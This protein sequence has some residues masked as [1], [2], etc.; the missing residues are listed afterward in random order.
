LAKFA[1][2]GNL[3]RSPLILLLLLLL[4]SCRA[5]RINPLDPKSPLFK[6]EGAISGTIRDWST[7]PVEGARIELEPGLF[8]ATSGSGGRYFIEK[9]HSGS[10]TA[11]SSKSFYS[12]E[13]LLVDVRVG[14]TATFDFRLDHLAEFSGLRASTHD[15]SSGAGN[16]LYATFEASVTDP[17]GFVVDTLVRL[18]VD[19]TLSRPMTYLGGHSF[20]VTLPDDSLPGGSLEYLAGRAIRLEATD[21]AGRRSVSDPF[22]I[23]RIIYQIPMALSP[24]GNAPQNPVTFKWSGPKPG[25][26]FS[27]ALHVQEVFP[28]N[29]RSWVREGIPSDSTSFYLS[30]TLTT[31]GTFLWS[32]R[33]VDMFG[34][35]ATSQLEM[36]S[37]D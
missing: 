20:A 32:I 29:T 24:I 37:V 25:F 12:S 7:G 36:F 22:S 3:N 1:Q 9:I 19:S 8:S 2:G 35:T 4:C 27:Y 21:D 13:T 10:Y 11:I 16:E 26:Q 33:I 6:D 15:D 14:D 17:D 30:D 31:S 28:S 34:N 23:S 18:V 5:E